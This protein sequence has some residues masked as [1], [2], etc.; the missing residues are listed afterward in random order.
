MCV[1]AH[2]REKLVTDYRACAVSANRRIFQ[3]LTVATSKEEVLGPRTAARV[4]E[5]FNKHTQLSKGK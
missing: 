4:A 5:E 1:A 3:V 2:L